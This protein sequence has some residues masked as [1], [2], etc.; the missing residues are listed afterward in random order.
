MSSRQ[1]FGDA[2]WS[3]YPADQRD[4]KEWEFSRALVFAGTGARIQRF[5]DKAESG[6]GVV[7]S[8]VGGSVSKGRGLRKQTYHLRGGGGVRSAMTQQGRTS[9]LTFPVS[10]DPTI[11]GNLYNPLNLHARVFEFVNTTF[12]ALPVARHDH[13][14]PSSA[15]EHDKVD[16]PRTLAYSD[17]VEFGYASSATTDEEHQPNPLIRRQR[18][19]G[20]KRAWHPGYWFGSHR[21]HDPAYSS[22][23][24][25]YIGQN[26]FVNGAQG[27]VG[28]D[29]FSGCWKEHVPEDS[30]LVL[31]ELGIN[32]MRWGYCHFSNTAKQLT[33]CGKRR[34]RDISVMETYELLLRSLL[35][36]PSRPAVINV[37][38]V[39]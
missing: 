6:R 15:S 8:V 37:Q 14:S 28:S 4:F 22:S 34:H 17:P 35:E 5:L 29:Y 20:S 32:D 31:V 1:R 9:G 23:A 27:G 12:P 26:V 16:V 10:D 24:G 7:V 38:W 33:G 11:I 25:A 2:K 30:D 18:L 19:A 36:M 39:V 13:P 3:N 21:E